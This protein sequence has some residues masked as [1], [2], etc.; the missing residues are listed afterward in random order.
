MGKENGEICGRRTEEQSC[1]NCQRTGAIA[2]WK[3]FLRGGSP[4]C[5][6]KTPP[7]SRGCFE[8]QIQRPHFSRR[9]ARRISRFGRSCAFYA[10]IKISGKQGDPT[11]RTNRQRKRRRTPGKRARRWERRQQS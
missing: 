1:S 3:Q 6:W 9:R 4:R 8:V 5:G 11:S 10:D 2:C 7:G